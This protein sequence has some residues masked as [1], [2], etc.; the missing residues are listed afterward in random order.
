MVGTPRAQ[1]MAGATVRSWS[2]DGHGEQKHHHHEGASHG[3]Q[4]RRVAAPRR[5]ASGFCWRRSDGCRRWRP[6]RNRRWSGHVVGGAVAWEQKPSLLH[7][8]CIM[9]HQE[10]G[11]LSTHNRSSP[12][13]K[14]VARGRRRREGP[15][16]S[17]LQQDTAAR[18][19]THPLH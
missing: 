7:N 6:Q 3:T 9:I 8:Q 15:P 18:H 5:R 13:P 19:R 1:R 2:E 11:N 4:A 14:P 16:W 10:H 17:S 12:S